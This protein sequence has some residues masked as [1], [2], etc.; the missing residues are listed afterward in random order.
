M[1]RKKEVPMQGKT[2]VI[3]ILASTKKRYREEMIHAALS[4]EP[5]YRC[6]AASS[7]DTPCKL[8]KKL[9]EDSD[10]RVLYCAANNPATPPKYA[11]QAA[12]GCKDLAE[13]DRQIVKFE[14]D[15]KA[16][17]AMLL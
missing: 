6:I 8:L 5:L 13:A 10:K 15:E 7:E 16:Y 14:R 4:D 1:Y 9:S 17:V 12:E 2:P 11:A 3:F